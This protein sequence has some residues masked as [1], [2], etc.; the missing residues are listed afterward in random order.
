MYESLPED[1]IHSNDSLS[2]SDEYIDL[3]EKCLTIKKYIYPFST[4]KVI[5]IEDIKHIEMIEMGRLTGKYTFIG[6]TWSMMWLHMDRKRPLKTFCIT[7]DDGSLTR[8]GITPD[9]PH[10]VFRI[11]NELRKSCKTKKLLPIKEK[12]D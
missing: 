6:Y 2:Y 4:E 3:N 5:K 7:I 12:Q 10:K 11:I 1:D 9:D 8:T